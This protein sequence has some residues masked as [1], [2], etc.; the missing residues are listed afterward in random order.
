MKI[1]KIDEK[2]IGTEVTIKG[3]IR[4]VRDQK[5]F[6]FINVNDGSQ[7]NGLQIVASEDRTKNYTTIIPQLTVGAAISATGT[8]VKSPAPEQPVEL[9]AENI[10]LI[11]T[12]PTEEYPLQKK[13]HSFEF[14]RTIAHLRPR[15]NTFGAVARVRNALAFASHKFFQE[16][17]FLYIMTP[18]ITGSDCEGAGQMFQVT[19]LKF[20]ELPKTATGEI[21][22]T[23]D[24]FAHPT[25][26][27][28]SGQL[29]VETACC[30]LGNVYTFGPT[31][32]AENSN[33]SR[34]LAEFWMIEPEIAFADI[35]D[36]MDLAEAY[37]KYV[38]AHLFENCASDMVFF[39]KFIEKGLI[40]RLKNVINNPFE[41]ITYTQAI[42]L[43]EKAPKKF[44]FPV[45]WGCDLQSEHER[46]LTEELFKKPVI[47]TGYPKE[48]K[49][50]YMRRNKD[51][52]TVA[53]MDVLVPGIGELIG[54]S[55]REERLDVLEKR[56]EE[57]QLDKKNYWWYLE[58]RKYGSI[59]HAGFGVG[60]ERLV[61]FATGMEN[62]RDVIPFPRYPGHAE[63]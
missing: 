37:L 35:N 51:D 49:A 24:F 13:R 40:D 39:D 26:L 29:N 46:Y 15:T 47:V 25:F 30:A 31:F 60:F 59:P 53:A 19:T 22:Y 23:K 4:T 14:L 8:L 34:H 7:I 6:T 27:T 3:W 44:E 18:I 50:F 52:K 32:R 57:M 48:I 42:E 17:G 21:D 11:G 58:L 5:N 56:L 16:H 12:C 2:F 62:I 1:N 55:Q 63:F 45:K 41:R 33:T 20:N 54:G 61:L 36:D 38:I 10:T 9:Q 43:L 28:V